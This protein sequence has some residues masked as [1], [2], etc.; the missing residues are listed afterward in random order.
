MRMILTDLHKRVLS[1]DKFTL[2]VYM[3]PPPSGSVLG[4]AQMRTI[5][6]WLLSIQ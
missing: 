4:S 2:N 3:E 6:I 1:A 5:L